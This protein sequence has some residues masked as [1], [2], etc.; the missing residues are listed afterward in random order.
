MKLNP[1]VSVIETFKYSFLGT[2]TFDWVNL[3]YSFVIT[4]ALLFIG[5]RMFNRVE[6]N[7]MDVI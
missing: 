3:I 6:R 7:F 4:I 5:M 1:M 2:G